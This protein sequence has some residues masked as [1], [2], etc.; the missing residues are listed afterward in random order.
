M[1]MQDDDDRYDTT[2]KFEK[3][4]AEAGAARYVL[5]LYVAGNTPRS[6]QAIENIRAI[7]ENKLRGRYTLEVIDIYQQP[8][9]ARQSQVIAAPTLI[10]ALPPP[11]RRIIGDLSTT[12][13]ILI[14]LNL[15][16]VGDALEPKPGEDDEKA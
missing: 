8:E 6:A 15:E 12:E 5:R 16:P 4:L 2:E 3:A 1:T 13:R 9:L 14:G 7:C 10:K 11:L